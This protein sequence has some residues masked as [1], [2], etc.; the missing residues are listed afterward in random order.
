M[1]G[2]LGKH[3]GETVSISGW[4]DVRRDH[5]KLVFLDIR[6]RSGKVQCVCLP[7]HAEAVTTAQTL[8]PEWVV[9]I[10]GMVNERPENMR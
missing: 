10:E 4:V 8:R 3:V 1:I 7:N 9:T 2:E 6:D 5:G